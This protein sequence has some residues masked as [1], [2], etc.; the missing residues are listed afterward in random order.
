MSQIQKNNIDLS[1]QTENNKQMQPKTKE[2]KKDI[3]MSFIFISWGQ[4][5][6]WHL[7]F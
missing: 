7:S 6:R 2:P 5:V 1:E 4:S 3:L